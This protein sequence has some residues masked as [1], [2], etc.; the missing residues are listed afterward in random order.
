[1][2]QVVQNYRTGKLGV[3]EI[4]PPQVNPASVLVRTLYSAISAGTEKTKVDTAKMSLWQKAKSRPDLVRKVIAKAKK[5]GWPA[6]FKMVQERLDEPVPLGYSLVG[7][8]EAVGEW[9]EGMQTGDIVAGAG[10]GFAN[11]AEV[12]V[13]PGR[14]AVR[15]PEK[16]PLDEAA[17]TTIGSIALQGVRQAAPQMG[18]RMVVTGLGLLG[19]IT[20]LL[21]KANGCFVFG[22]EKNPQKLKTALSQGIVSDGA[23]A[24]E[25]GLA[26]TVAQWTRGRGADAVLLTASTPSNGPIEQAGLF[27]R[28]RGRVVIVGAVGTQFPREPFYRKEITI[29]MARSYG[30]G[31]Y[32]PFYETLGLD[33]PAGYVRF[34]EQRNMEAFLDLLAARYIDLKPLITHRFSIEEAARAFDLLQEADTPHLGILL[35]YAPPD[36]GRSPVRASRPAATT[37]RHPSPD[38]VGFIGLGHYATAQ[39]LPGLKKT[40]DV[41]L[42]KVCTA[43]GLKAQMR[44]PEFG[45]EEAVPSPDDILQDPEIGTVFIA[46]RHDSHAA[47]VT[48]ALRQGKNVF[49]EKPLCLNR[50][51]LGQIRQAHDGSPGLL[52]VG[53]NRRFSPLVAD[54]RNRFPRGADHILCRVNAGTL[55][56]DHWLN[57]PE[58]GGGRLLG[59]ACHFID[60]A[61]HL[62]ASPIQSV[63]AQ[64]QVDA[65]TSPANTQNG[66]LTLTLKNGNLATVLYFASGDSRLPK[67]Y[68]EMHG[69]GQSAI[70]DDFVSLQIA[71]QKP[72]KEPKQNKGQEEML[73]AFMKACREGGKKAPPI[74]SDMLWNTASA[75]L[76]ALESLGQGRPIFIDV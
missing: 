51:E 70:L 47:L 54:I 19:Q 27:C 69:G 20:A 46:T 45:F 1:M 36:T 65:A 62:G 44:G 13:I 26:E 34:T 22:V 40:G 15:V 74:G 52:M 67:E 35:E 11:H 18:E 38:T 71:G 60:L 33:Y 29:R 32:D 42:K 59:E 3:E 16:T 7:R 50:E 21:L 17:F 2:K 58:T 23:L 53:F 48:A 68:F 55:P 49:V 24:D 37:A 72:R 14:L 25:A 12:N 9:V 5:E 43:S 57:I 39:I 73:S 56:E 30:P 66:H 41:R 4:P 8:V 6:T 76:A 75:T 31:R 64:T 10:A 28:E 63:F 61:A